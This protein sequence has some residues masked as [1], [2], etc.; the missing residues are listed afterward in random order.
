MTLKAGRVPHAH[1]EDLQ[2]FSFNGMIAS[3]TWL[4]KIMF[5]FPN[6]VVINVLKSNIV[7]YLS[8]EAD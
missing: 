8:L 1:C 4:F 6:L 3:G 2:I 5:H 7:D